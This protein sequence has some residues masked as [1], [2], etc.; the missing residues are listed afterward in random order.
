MEIARVEVIL[1]VEVIP[2]TLD[3]P[4]AMLKQCRIIGGVASHIRVGW[5]SELG[6]LSEL[7]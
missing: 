2:Y 7:G 4:K 6:K 5:L 1:R 3:S